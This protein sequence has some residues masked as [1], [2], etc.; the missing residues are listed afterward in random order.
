MPHSGVILVDMEVLGRRVQKVVPVFIALARE[1]RRMAPGLLGTNVLRVSLDALHGK[2][3]RRFI[4]KV[5]QKSK[6]WYSVLKCVNDD[7]AW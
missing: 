4:L 3:G 2:H 6:T 1:F 5:R 7:G